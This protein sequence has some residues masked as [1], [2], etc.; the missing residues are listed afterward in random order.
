LSPSQ[1]SSR[2]SH[3]QPTDHKQCLQPNDKKV[4]QLTHGFT[5]G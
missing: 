2:F 5:C 1:P 3:R 4:G